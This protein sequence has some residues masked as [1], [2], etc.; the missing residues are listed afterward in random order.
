MKYTNVENLYST[1]LIWQQKQAQPNHHLP[2]FQKILIHN[3]TKYPSMDQNNYIIKKIPNKPRCSLSFLYALHP[4]F[5]LFMS[6]KFAGFVVGGLGFGKI[7]LRNLALLGKWLWRYLRES[8]TLWHQVILSI[9]G[10]HS[11]G[12]DANTLVKWSHRCPWK[13]IA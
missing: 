10:T 5:F 2:R 8:T 9:Y 12:W 11:N 7:S 4:I 3:F 13:A 6:S 1:K